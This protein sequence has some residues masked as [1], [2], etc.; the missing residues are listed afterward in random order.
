MKHY[1]FCTTYNKPCITNS[2]SGTGV[3]RVKFLYW[4][5]ITGTVSEDGFI[6][7]ELK[8]SDIFDKLAFDCN[9]QGKAI[10]VSLLSHEMVES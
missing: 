4:E 3:V 9:S 6:C 8:I 10:H 2:M 7:E 5:E 1:L